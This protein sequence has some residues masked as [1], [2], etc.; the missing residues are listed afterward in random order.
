MESKND[1]GGTVALSGNSVLTARW[2][3]DDNP[4]YQHLSERPVRAL[5]QMSRIAK[6][7][8]SGFDSAVNNVLELQD[9]FKAS[10]YCGPTALLEGWHR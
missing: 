2:I 6:S 7:L 8:F 9:C 10:R 1:A 3:G 4:C 5:N